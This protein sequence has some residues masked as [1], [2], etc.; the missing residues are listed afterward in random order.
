MIAKERK[1][2]ETIIITTTI[3]ERATQC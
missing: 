2:S 3:H 1:K